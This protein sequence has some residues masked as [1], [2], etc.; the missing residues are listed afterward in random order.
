MGQIH[1]LEAIVDGLLVSPGPVGA[2][3]PAVGSKMTGFRDDRAQQRSH[4]VSS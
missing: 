3:R 2:I 4:E 1:Q